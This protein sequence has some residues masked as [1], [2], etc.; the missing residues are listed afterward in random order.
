[1]QPAA[2]LTP[3]P[4][5]GYVAFEP[6]TGTTAQ[7]ETEEEALANLRAA[8]ACPQF[9]IEPVTGRDWHKEELEERLADYHANPDAGSPWQE[10]KLR[11]LAR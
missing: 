6:E 8:A 5:G 11:I 4:E 10:V 9:T 1:M 2:I 7:G 3:A